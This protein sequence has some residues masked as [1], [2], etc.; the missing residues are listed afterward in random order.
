MSFSRKA[1]RFPRSGHYD[2]PGFLLRAT[3]DCVR[4]RDVREAPD[5]AVTVWLGLRDPD[6]ED[7]TVLSVFRR[8]DW[9]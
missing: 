2:P 9:L 8:K 4:C 6:R 7:L 1:S 3:V 5:E